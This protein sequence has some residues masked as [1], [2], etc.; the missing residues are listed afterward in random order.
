[1]GIPNHIVSNRWSWWRCV[2]A[3]WQLPTPWRDLSIVVEVLYVLI[4]CE[5]KYSPKGENCSTRPLGQEWWNFVKKYIWN[6]STALLLQL[7][8]S[9]TA[10]EDAL[11][12]SCKCICRIFSEVR[13]HF[14]AVNLS[15]HGP[16]P[17]GLR[18]RFS[19]F[20]NKPRY[21]YKHTHNIRLELY[22]YDRTK[23]EI[24]FRNIG[25]FFCIN[26]RIQTVLTFRDRVVFICRRTSLIYL[27][28]LRAEW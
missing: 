16:T 8:A 22:K 15:K 27:I 12:S 28:F 14:Y 25:T 3:I 1:M 21:I 7:P 23:T 2:C 11:C 5:V 17:Q 24:L 18:S 4:V 19:R 26:I 13:S 20:S 10:A 9:L 6:T